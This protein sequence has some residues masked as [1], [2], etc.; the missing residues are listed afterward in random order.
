MATSTSAILNLCLKCASLRSA[1]NRVSRLALLCKDLTQAAT[2]S[3][4]MVAGQGRMIEMLQSRIEALEVKF[5]TQQSQTQSAFRSSAF[6]NPNPNPN[7]T[8]AQRTLSLQLPPPPPSM[9]LNPLPTFLEVP[10]TPPSAP[11]PT[12]AQ[13]ESE[14]EFSMS[15]HS[16]TPFF[17]TTHD[18]AIGG[19]RSLSE[20]PK[21]VSSP[22]LSSHFLMQPV[23]PPS[24]SQCAKHNRSKSR[25]NNTNTNTNNNNSRSNSTSSLNLHRQPSNPWQTESSTALAFV[26]SPPQTN[27]DSN[28]CL[29]EILPLNLVPT[30]VKPTQLDIR[31]SELLAILRPTVAATLH[32]HSIIK[33]TA[34]H[35]KQTLGAQCFPVG[36]FALKTYLPDEWLRM[37]AFLCQG[38]EQLWFMKVNEVLCKA[39]NS[40]EEEEG[41]EEGKEENNNKRRPKEEGGHEHVLSNVNFVNTGET[42]AIRCTVDS[43]TVDMTA[44][45]IEELYQ[46]TFLEECDLVLGK[47]HLLKNSLIL[48]KAWWLYES[49]VVTG[50][51][52][53]QTIPDF[54]LSVM[55]LH[56]INKHHRQVHHPL[57][58]L[59]IFFNVY[60]KLDWAYE[61]VSMEEIVKVEGEQIHRSEVDADAD[62]D[63]TPTCFKIS[64][65]N[66]YRQR[67][68]QS[69]ISGRTS[70]TTRTF[71][72][73]NIAST[74]ASAVLDKEAANLNSRKCTLDSKLRASMFVVGAMNIVNP[75][76]AGENLMEVSGEAS[77][78]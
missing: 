28:G 62:D 68:N 26:S 18:G 74:H 3:D 72:T 29:N 35:V 11:A 7:P 38:Q 78:P 54:A 40:E 27:G 67:Y 5:K 51:T 20:A 65:L 6:L 4:Q 50:S 34:Q 48:L 37:S 9:I 56:I 8:P 58:I 33:Y 69:R 52:I 44:N 76:D 43:V 2:L 66:K 77:E 31:V 71:S 14:S 63:S 60:S 45:N 12:P 15:A 49:R 19:R 42:R 24:P 53:L 64:L 25:D 39:S 13:A 21:Q 70:S 75:L 30:N 47:N 61:G 36:A 1:Q 59:A 16:P 17:L 55:M 10:Y 57:Q 46:T 32:R 73:S 22:I 41:K 23:T